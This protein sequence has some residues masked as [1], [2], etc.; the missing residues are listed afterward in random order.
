M[1][2]LHPTGHEDSPFFML[3]FLQRLTKELWIVQGE[4]EDH[5]DVGAMANK[6]DKVLLLQ[7]HQKHYLVASVDPSSASS[8]PSATIAA[9][10]TGQVT[11]GGRS[12]GQRGK[13]CAR[14]GAAAASPAKASTPSPSGNGDTELH[15]QGLFGPLLL[16]LVV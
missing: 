16:P 2:E 12:G 5:E 15:R 13:G 7:N 3:L 14:G 10:K 9:V 4:V 11:R 1:A 8:Q 6:A